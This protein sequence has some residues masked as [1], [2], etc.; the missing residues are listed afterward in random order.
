[1]KVRIEKSKILPAFEFFSE[2]IEEAN[3]KF[4]DRGLEAVGVDRPMVAVC[5]IKIPKNQF[6][7]YELEK[8]EENI[9]LNITNFVTFLKRAENFVELSLDGKLIMK[10]EN[11]RF[12]IPILTDL[13][14]EVPPIDQLEHNSFVKLKSEVFLTAIADAD[15]VSDSLVIEIGDKVR[16]FAEGDILSAVMELERGN[17]NLMDFKGQAK[18]RYPLDY[19]KKLKTKFMEDQMTIF[20]GIDYP[21]KISFGNSF[22]ILAP[23]VSDEE[24]TEEEKKIPETE[25]TEKEKDKEGSEDEE[26]GVESGE[27]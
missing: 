22:L 14:E 10:T 13:N 25:L 21:A 20:T 15:V 7:K 17:S 16:V 26:E 19:L 12:T 23:R 18:S 6:D 3:I 24:E 9:G 8:L 1:M 4:T 5:S 2:Y 27:E 11:R